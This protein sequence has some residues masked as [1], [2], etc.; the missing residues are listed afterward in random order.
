M[1]HALKKSPA[2]A[3]QCNPAAVREAQTELNI[4]NF[5]FNYTYIYIITFSI[6]ILIIYIIT[7]LTFIRYAY[8][9]S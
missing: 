2:T 1:G 8:K 3:M 5:Y 7:T 4:I 6:L 9:H